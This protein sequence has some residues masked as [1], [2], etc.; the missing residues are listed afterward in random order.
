VKAMILVDMVGAKTLRLKRETT[1]TPWLVD[2]IWQKASEMGYSRIFVK[3]S[4]SA[5]DDHIPFLEL[6]IPAIDLLDLEYPFWHRA[7][8]TLDKL[9]AGNM[10]I[11]G[12]VV[13][14][15]LPLIDLR[16]TVPEAVR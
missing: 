2:L 3:D 15:S 5:L 10:E 8:D 14:K 9:D 12:R 11:V 13:L 4:F 1:S 6:G 7:G 16:L